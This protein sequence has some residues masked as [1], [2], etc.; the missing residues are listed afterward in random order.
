VSKHT[1]KANVATPTKGQIASHVPPDSAA[2]WEA[3]GRQ[4]APMLGSYSAAIVT[5]SDE[6]AAAHVA[7]GIG[8]AEAEHRRVAIGDL[9]GELEPIQSLVSSDDPHGISDSFTFGVSLNR[10]AQ[11]IDTTGNLFV[12]PSGTGS[13]A[14][15]EIFKNVRW[16]RL[17][18]GFREVGALLLLVA[19]ADAP[20]LRELIDHMDGVVLVGTSPL[21]YAPYINVLARVPAPIRPLQRNG[22]PAAKPK[23]V[24]LISLLLLVLF[25]LVAAGIYWRYLD[26]GT[27]DKRPAFRN[28][29]PRPTTPQTPA[30]TLTVGPP[31]NLADS[32]S[33]AAYAV[34]L[35]TWNAPDDAIA[36]LR[37]NQSSLPAGTVSPVPVGPNRDTYYKLITG[38]FTTK[39][40]A[41]SL[42]ARLKQQG[43]VR[44]MPGTVVRTPYALLLDSATAGHTQELVR[45]YAGTKQAVYVLAQRDGTLKLYAGAFER[46]EDS[47][48]LLA[49]LRSAALHPVL[50]YRTGRTP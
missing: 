26:H 46:P 29:A 30:E 24:W 12:M 8:L 4:I 44:D 34:E 22:A 48:T 41:D 42:L 6:L 27:P 38:A 31:G 14:D 47:G 19:P 25:S 21:D 49:T 40:G 10:I 16:H 7:L 1:P 33:A 39:T 18:N 43:V 28:P 17:A 11:P 45:K 9:V 36:T 3:A 13:V 23:P 2:G 37:R 5:S 32:T 20:G 15:P 35:A 50:V